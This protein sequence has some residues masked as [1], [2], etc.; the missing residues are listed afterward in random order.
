MCCL[1]ERLIISDFCPFPDALSVLLKDLASFEPSI[2]AEIGVAVLND[3]S[4]RSDVEF[5]RPSSQSQDSLSSL[6]C[7]CLLSLVVATGDTSKI[8]AA[9]SEILM[10]VRVQVNQSIHVSYSRFSL[11]VSSS[12]MLHMQGNVK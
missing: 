7:A 11:F 10:S 9:L 4:S 3:L 12:E 8:L 6:A 5:L 1:L 2:C